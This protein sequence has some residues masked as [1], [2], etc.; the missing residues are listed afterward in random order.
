MIETRKQK[1][2]K[3]EK[4]IFWIRVFAGVGAV[5]VVVTLF[6]LHRG[7]TLSQIFYLAIIYSIVTL[8]FELP[9]SYMADRWGRKKTLLVGIVVLL[10]S[11]LVFLFAHSFL[12]FAIGTSFFAVYIACF[13][14]TVEA[15]LYD[16]R[17]E[18]GQT[19]GS[20]SSF[21][22]FHSGQR[23][24]KI[25]VPILGAFIVQDLLEW[26][27]QLLI[28]IDLLTVTIAMFLTM[29]LTEANHFMDIEKSEKG[30]MKDAWGVVVHNKL[31]RKTIL[32][33]TLLF[34]GSFI[35]WRIYQKFFVDLGVTVMTIGISI[36]LLQIATFIFLQKV[37]YFT[38]RFSTTKVINFINLLFFLV[39]LVFI[40]LMN[41]SSTKFAILL[42][43]LY[44][45]Y[46]LLEIVRAP[47]FSEIYN[48]AS[49]SF[50]RSTTLSLVS[51]LKSILDIPLLFL[52]A[53]MVKFDVSFPFY[54]TFVLA[55]IVVL[56]LRLPK[57]IDTMNVDFKSPSY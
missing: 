3:N 45:S 42:L 54:I 23:L 41:F 55:L 19:E 7:L 49:F 46:I 53:I 29:K 8:L 18:L 1:L 34:I 35:A 30:I 15:L 38:S 32:N 47:F 9:S 6:Y 33:K 4:I 56:F 16:S 27:F 5:N 11:W 21:G 17:L 24:A 2:Q 12:M 14:G 36:S 52:A 31:L 44:Q 28:A 50:N 40:V 48:K 26:Q 10:L 51:L 13:S 57:E 25:F 37:H 43:F 39:T 20:V 22:K